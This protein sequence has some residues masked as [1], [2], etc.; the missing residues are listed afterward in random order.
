MVM[1]SVNPYGI[2][3]WK[4]LTTAASVLAIKIASPADVSN[5]TK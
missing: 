4:Y 1:E 3:S 2:R 5:S